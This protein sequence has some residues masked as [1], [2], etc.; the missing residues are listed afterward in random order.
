MPRRQGGIITSR[1]EYRGRF[2]AC[3]LVNIAHKQSERPPTFSIGMIGS[4]LD[5]TS[6]SPP[7][8]LLQMHKQTEEA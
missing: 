4:S 7:H 6:L 3:F 5:Q 1:H 2:Q 8:D